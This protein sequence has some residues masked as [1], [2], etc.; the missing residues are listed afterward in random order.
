MNAK[1]ELVRLFDVIV[2]LVILVSPFFNYNMIFLGIF[3]GA[4]WQL[5]SYGIIRCTDKGKQNN[6]REVY[7]LFARAI[8]TVFTAG[9]GLFLVSSIFY[10]TA[11]GILGY[12]FLLISFIAA[13]F[14]T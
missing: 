12:L 3:I 4:F 11:L 13:L 1:Q 8:L 7:W 10:A 2:Q 14:F 6:N 9:L 5:C